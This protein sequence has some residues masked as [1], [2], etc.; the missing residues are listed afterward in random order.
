[1][2]GRDL[3]QTEERKYLRTWILQVA[4]HKKQYHTVHDWSTTETKLHFYLWYTS[5][6]QGLIDPHPARS[7]VA[8]QKR[9]TTKRSL[10][11]PLA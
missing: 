10:P 6:I 5:I 1:M 11:I 8:T 7:P 4:L 9:R 3:A 2:N